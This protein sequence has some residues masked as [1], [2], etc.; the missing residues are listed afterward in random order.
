MEG[1]QI[2]LT[3]LLQTQDLMDMS[4]GYSLPES[5]RPNL[6]LIAKEWLLSNPMNDRGLDFCP[7]NTLACL[8]AL[9]GDEVCVFMSCTCV[10]WKCTSAALP[11]F[12]HRGTSLA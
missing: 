11:L 1:G 10:L 8:H 2:E 5:W 9:P 4:R 12:S 6:T 3:A 7:I